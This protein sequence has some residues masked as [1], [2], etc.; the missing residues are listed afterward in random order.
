MDNTI[1]IEQYK[2]TTMVSKIG[3][4]VFCIVNFI[5]TFLAPS[6]LQYFISLVNCL[7][8]IL[9]LPILYFTVP[10]NAMNIFETLLPVVGFDFLEVD[11]FAEVDYLTMW[12]H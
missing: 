1:P 5:L 12:L 7:Q 11:D 10:A 4:I 8:L 2:L 6:G 3:L 9:H